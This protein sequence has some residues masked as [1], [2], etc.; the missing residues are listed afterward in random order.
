M[1]LIS[2]YA[3]F[4]DFSSY[5]SWIRLANLDLLTHH[6]VHLL[7]DLVLQL[8]VAAVVITWQK[9]NYFVLLWPAVVMSFKRC[10]WVAYA[11]GSRA[12]IVVL[13]HHRRWLHNFNDLSRCRQNWFQRKALLYGLRAESCCIR[14]WWSELC[15]TICDVA[16]FGF[17]L[18][19]WLLCLVCWGITATFFIMFHWPRR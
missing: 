1:V 17:P 7:H 11:L 6:L 16:A 10:L 4:P 8:S 9:S 14:H 18:L 3:S 5:W 15:T 2:I 12:L 13:D 19:L